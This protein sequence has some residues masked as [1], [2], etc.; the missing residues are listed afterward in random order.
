[1]GRGAASPAGGAEGRGLGPCGCAREALAV[2]RGGVPSSCHVPRPASP[3]AVKAE[4]HPRGAGVSRRPRAQDLPATL[5][6]GATPCT[7]HSGAGLLLV[8]HTA[9]GGQKPGGGWTP[10]KQGNRAPPPA[11]PQ[12]P[13]PLPTRRPSSPGS[14]RPAGSPRRLSLTPQGCLLLWCPGWQTASRNPATVPTPPRPPRTFCP[15]RAYDHSRG[16]STPGPRPP[17]RRR[18]QSHLHLS[19]CRCSSGRSFHNDKLASTHALA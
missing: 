14:L 15:G 1:M 8:P 11:S 2:C 13:V 18:H 7:S 16:T 9:Q 12:C 19:H 5:R 3:T 4:D 17:L 6:S 10:E